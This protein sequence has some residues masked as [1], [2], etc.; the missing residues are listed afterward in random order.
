MDI[1]ASFCAKIKRM[2]CTLQVDP[3]ELGYF[4]RIDILGDDAYIKSTL[5]LEPPL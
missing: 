1:K 5:R 2:R 3:L 4:D